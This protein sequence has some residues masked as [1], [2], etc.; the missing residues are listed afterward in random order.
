MIYIAGPYSEFNDLML[1]NDRAHMHG[2]F[3]IDCAVAGH[4]VYS[5]IAAWHHLSFGRGLPMTQEFWR[6]M[7]LGIL[8]HCEQLW[9]L[10]LEGW[11][12]SS[13]LRYE[14]PFADS[15][16]IPTRYFD[17]GTYREEIGIPVIVGPLGPGL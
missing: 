1:M 3:A 8:R 7:S 11:G 16:G 14:I 5:P 12:K 9:I 10:R 4:I 2:V 17:W 13:G 15:C 6:R